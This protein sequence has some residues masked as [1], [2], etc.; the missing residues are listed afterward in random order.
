LT[1]IPYD[2]SLG[3]FA[4]RDEDFDSLVAQLFDDQRF[5]LIFGKAS[6]PR[7]VVVARTIIRDIVKCR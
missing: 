2:R 3:A 6:P 7:D 4:I 1:N 5:G